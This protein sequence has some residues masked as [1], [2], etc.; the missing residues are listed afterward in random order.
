MPT[1]Q[2]QCHVGN[3][4][5]K[6]LKNKV[7]AIKSQNLEHHFRVPSINALNWTQMVILFYFDF[8]FNNMQNL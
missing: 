3:R 8:L 6:L 5:A 4:K 7:E 1:K 2:W